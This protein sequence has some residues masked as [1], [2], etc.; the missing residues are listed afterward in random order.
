[1]KAFLWPLIVTR[2]IEMRTV[3]VGIAL[4]QNQYSSDFPLQMT[5]ATLV[6]LPII[7]LFFFTQEYFMEGINLSGTNK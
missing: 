2:S 5:A 7:V 3:E 6:A 1:W 4:L